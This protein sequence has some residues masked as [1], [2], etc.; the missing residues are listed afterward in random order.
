MWT[1]GPWQLGRCTRE[2]EG[3][4]G[5]RFVTSADAVLGVAIAFGDDEA[6]QNANANLIAAAPDM[7]EALRDLL[8][9]ANIGEQSRDRNLADAARM[10]LAKARGEKFG[11]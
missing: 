6:N 10:A 8:A 9:W 1:N 4:E 7:Y 2:D 3:F 11:K 5:S